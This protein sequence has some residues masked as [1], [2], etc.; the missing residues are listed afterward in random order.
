MFDTIIESHQSK[1]ANDDADIPSI[2]KLREHCQLKAA[3]GEALSKFRESDASNLLKI[4]NWPDF[5]MLIEHKEFGGTTLIA[6]DYLNA[7]R[8]GR[9]LAKCDVHESTGYIEIALLYGPLL[10]HKSVWHLIKKEAHAI[11]QCHEWQFYPALLPSAYH[12][13]VQLNQL[14]QN[15]W[16]NG[17]QNKDIICSIEIEDGYLQ[18]FRAQIKEAKSLNE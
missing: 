3:T 13:I 8:K 7:R 2:K 10:I 9:E 17:G 5:C 16:K 12:F 4:L 15:A 14:L 1:A 11:Q 6:Q 18:R